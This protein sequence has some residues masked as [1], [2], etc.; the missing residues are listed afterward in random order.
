MLELDTV[1]LEDF[2]I[3]PKDFEGVYALYLNED[4]ELNMFLP[5]VARLMQI[6]IQENKPIYI[7][8]SESV[9]RRIYANHLQGVGASTVRETIWELL[10]HKK[11]L[12]T[13]AKFDIND[14]LNKNT[15]F[16]TFQTKEHCALESILRAKYNPI[17]NEGRK[18]LKTGMFK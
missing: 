8:E 17:L 16:T 5:E 12:D 2:K 1:K 14:W 7:G 13:G 11:L 4:V 6:C 3:A 15:Y 18:K 10:D 9:M